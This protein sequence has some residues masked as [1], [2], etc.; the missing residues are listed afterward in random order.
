VIQGTFDVIQGT[1]DVI[2]GTFSVIQETFSVI[3]GKFGMIQIMKIMIN[4]LMPVQQNC[5][6]HLRVP[7]ILTDRG[8]LVRRD[9]KCMSISFRNNG[10]RNAQCKGIF[11]V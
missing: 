10:V 11:E 4:M 2:Q 7:S 5:F 6:T 1:Y 9:S 8:I 3:Q